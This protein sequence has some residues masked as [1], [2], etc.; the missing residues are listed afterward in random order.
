MYREESYQRVIA[1]IN[2]LKKKQL[3]TSDLLSKIELTIRIQNLKNILILTSK[4]PI[5][6]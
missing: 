5:T 3:Q 6:E 1:R 4:Q 2:Y